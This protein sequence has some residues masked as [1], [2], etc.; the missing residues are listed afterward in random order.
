[1]SGYLVAIGINTLIYALLALG[2]NLQWGLTGMINFGVAGFYALGAY[3]SALLARA[4]VPV[5]AALAAA[6]LAAG[7]VAYPVSMTTLRLRADFLAVVTIG[8]S[9]VVRLLALNEEWLT[10]GPH[11][12]PGV[13][14][15]FAGLPRG[16]SDALLLAVLAAATLAV[17]AGLERVARSPYGRVLRAIREDEDAAAALGKETV[18]FKVQSAMAGSAVAGLAGGFYAHYVSYV[19]PDQFVPLV[20]FYVWIAVIVGG[21]GSNRGAVVGAALLMVLTEGTRFLNDLGFHFDEVR[22]SAVRFVLVGLG[23]VW[24]MLNRPEG[25]LPERIRASPWATGG[26]APAVERGGSP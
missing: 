25:L 2:L 11:G 23:L 8:F 19:V 3:T 26:G 1:M 9:E 6:T 22:L 14:R 20:T 4:G 5:V 15:L 13:P 24:I 16:Q 21:S 7:V 17:L 10:G 18:R 12:I